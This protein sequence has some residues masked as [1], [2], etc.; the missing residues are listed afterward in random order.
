MN[1]EIERKFL[2]SGDFKEFAVYSEPIKQGFISSDP[3]RSVRVRIKGKKAFLTIKGKSNQSGTTR[4]EFET[5]ISVK[6]AEHLLLI[7]KNKIIEKTR[8]YIPA[9]KHTYEIDVFEGENKGLIIA[10]IELKSEDEDY[11]KPDWLGE[12]LTGDIRFYNLYLSEKP[13]SSWHTDINK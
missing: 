11:I 5:E 13:Y 6:D 7:C 8:Y 2:V 9:G 12:E 10:E 4:Y 3:D 1:T